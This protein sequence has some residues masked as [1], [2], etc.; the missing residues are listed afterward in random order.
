MYLIAKV[1]KTLGTVFLRA[2]STKPVANSAVCIRHTSLQ[3]T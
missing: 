3:Q 1:I 2:S